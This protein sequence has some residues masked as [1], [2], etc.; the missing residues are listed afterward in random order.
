MDTDMQNDIKNEF[1]LKS[2]AVFE[3]HVED[4]PLT[5]LS[6]LI[7]WLT[8]FLTKFIVSQFA[9][10]KF[11]HSIAPTIFPNIL[12]TAPTFWIQSQMDDIVN[13]RLASSEKA[14]RND[15]LQL[16]LDA[17]ASEH[18]V[19]MK[20]KNENKILSIYSRKK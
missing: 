12:D 5:K 10:M 8:P 18:G 3:K 6:Y 19:C 2:A 15:L 11:L 9:L 14:K 1:M 4:L 7:P 20:K 16:L 17:A 13:A